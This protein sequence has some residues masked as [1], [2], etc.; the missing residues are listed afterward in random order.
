MT[1]TGI[2]SGDE[3]REQDC[4]VIVREILKSVLPAFLSITSPSAATATFF[5]VSLPVSHLSSLFFQNS[6]FLVVGVSE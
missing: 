6:Q 2:N 3:R 1:L 5:I 4:I